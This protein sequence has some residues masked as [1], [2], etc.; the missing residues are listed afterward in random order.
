MAWQC[1][2]GSAGFQ[3]MFD[4]HMAPNGWIVC[5]AL[6]G[7]ERIMGSCDYNHGNGEIIKWNF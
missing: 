1:T 5:F 7:G 4:D 3:L 6:V 2:S